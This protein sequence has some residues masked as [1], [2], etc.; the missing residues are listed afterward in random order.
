MSNEEL[1]GLFTTARKEASREREERAQ[2]FEP[3]SVIEP[4]EFLRL[5]EESESE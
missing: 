3:L 1:D 4:V 2:R 5:A